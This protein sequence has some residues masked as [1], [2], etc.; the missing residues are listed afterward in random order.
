MVR[1]DWIGLISPFYEVTGWR[2]ILVVVDYFL[3]FIWAKGYGVANQ[4][5]V[6]DF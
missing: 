4:E 1:I 3:L 6:H 2:Y 5:A